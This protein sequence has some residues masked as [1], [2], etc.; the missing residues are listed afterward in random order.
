M[1]L[2]SLAK[3]TLGSSGSQ[4]HFKSS[5]SLTMI[6]IGDSEQARQSRARLGPGVQRELIAVPSPKQLPIDLCVSEVRMRPG[7]A[8]PSDRLHVGIQGREQ[9]PAL[10]ERP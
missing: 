6:S 5:I 10:F 2:A 9:G 4:S 7:D 8:C 3:I 1:S